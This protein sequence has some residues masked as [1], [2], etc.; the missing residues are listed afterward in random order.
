MGV[1]A[2]LSKKLQTENV[3]GSARQCVLTVSEAI[4][5]REIDR[6]KGVVLADVRAQQQGLLLV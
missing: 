3:D 1:A 2:C 6:Q 5:I 4:Q